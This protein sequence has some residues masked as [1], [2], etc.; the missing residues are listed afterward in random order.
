MVERLVGGGDCRRGGS[1]LT[2]IALAAAEAARAIV[3]DL[4]RECRPEE[5]TLHS[6]DE[7]NL[8]LTAR[9]REEFG[10]AVH[11]DPLVAVVPE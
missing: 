5:L 10:L 8:L 1:G 4:A 2:A 11:Q 6:F 3:R 9:L 7:R